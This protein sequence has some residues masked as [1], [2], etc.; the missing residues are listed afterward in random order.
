MSDT[1]VFPDL[2][3]LLDKM[4]FAV[5]TCSGTSMLPFIC[6]A[7]DRI[8]I[9]K[10]SGKNLKKRDIVLFKREDGTLV[11]HRILKI[12]EKTFDACGDNTHIPLDSGVPLS[13]VL[14]IATGRFR[15]E[16]YTDFSTDH[17]YRFSSF[18][19][20]ASLFLRRIMLPVCRALLPVYHKK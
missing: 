5:I 13:S 11:L 1:V 20:C 14:G 4:G 9:I 12:T 17:S 3:A 16:K 6:N 19:W 8:E 7:T 15:G 10:N 18:L 2:E